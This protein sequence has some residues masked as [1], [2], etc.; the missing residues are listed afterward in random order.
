MQPTQPSPHTSFYVKPNAFSNYLGPHPDLNIDHDKVN[1]FEDYPS[2]NSEVSALKFRI[3]E[4][5][6]VNAALEGK[7]RQYRDEIRLFKKDVKGYKNDG[8]R[9]TQQLKDKNMEITALHTKIIQLLNND[10]L[11]SPQ[12]VTSNSSGFSTKISTANS[13]ATAKQR[14]GSKAVSEDLRNRSRTTGHR[15]DAHLKNQSMGWV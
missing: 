11:A 6:Y 13:H 5:E 4:L 14:K 10:T 12:T 3:V 15:D 2:D 9:F 1:P 7:L 8:R